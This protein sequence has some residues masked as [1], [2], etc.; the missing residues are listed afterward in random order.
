MQPGSRLLRILGFADTEVQKGC[1]CVTGC[2]YIHIY[3]KYKGEIRRRVSE[4]LGSCKAVMS[5]RG[6]RTIDEVGKEKTQLGV[7]DNAVKEKTRKPRKRRRAI[8]CPALFKVQLH[9]TLAEKLHGIDRN[10]GRA[11]GSM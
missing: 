4:S 6:N 9:G 1:V 5:G 2:I 8:L 11:R 10:G 3:I 7:W